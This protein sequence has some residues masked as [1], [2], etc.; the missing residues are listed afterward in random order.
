LAD[1]LNTEDDKMT[2]N[3][4]DMEHIKDMMQRG[5]MTP[6]E[7]NVYKVECMRILLVTASIP[8]NVRRALNAAVKSGRLEH[9][10]KDGNK[11][12]AFYKK[13]FE[14]MAKEGRH[15]HEVKVLNS[16]IEVCK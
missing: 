12:E 6:D 8:S 5:L 15:N 1:N 10:K 2:I 7:A 11:P 16:I 4:N 13:G 3:Q 9:M 14:Y